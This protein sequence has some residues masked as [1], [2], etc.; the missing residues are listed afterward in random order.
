MRVLQDG[1]ELARSTL[2]PTL[3]AGLRGA[4]ITWG[5]GLFGPLAGTLLN[6][7]PATGA[8]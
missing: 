7:Y 4:K 2:A 1:S 3:V 5:R 6:R 8:N